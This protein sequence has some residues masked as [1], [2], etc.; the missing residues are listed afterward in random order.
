M[1]Q[2]KKLRENKNQHTIKNNQS[3]LQDNVA[4]KVTL[5]ILSKLRL[6]YP[7]LEF[8]MD[9]TFLTKKLE[10]M[11]SSDT[12]CHKKTSL[13]PDGGLLWVI[14]EGKKYY[15]LILEQKKQGTNDSRLIEGK[16]KQ[17]KGNAVERL[18]KNVIGFEILFGDEDIN[19]LVV[20][21]QG[22]DF[23]DKESTIPDR[24]RTIFRFL[25]MNQIN[26]F[27]I[28]IQKYNWSAGSFFMRGHSMNDVPGTS[29]WTFDEMSNIG[30]NV[31]EQSIE[32]Y[33]YKYGK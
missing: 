3:Q 5:Y 12:N 27:K 23:F 20:F 4:R 19:P 25:P 26:L 14:I 29:D 11:V 31:A 8:G 18:G 13:K 33:L 10:K 28:Q 30:L 17:G 22:C 21:L 9:T 2:S 6:K 1:S 7:L 16:L 32:Y 15:I 24:V